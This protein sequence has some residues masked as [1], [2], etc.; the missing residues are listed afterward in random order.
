[1]T[2]LQSSPELP[3]SCFFVRT[4]FPELQRDRAFGSLIRLVV[5]NQGAEGTEEGRQKTEEPSI[6]PKKCLSKHDARGTWEKRGPSF[7]SA[8]CSSDIEAPSLSS[9][10][11]ATLP[12][13]SSP[14]T[15]SSHP[16]PVAQHLASLSGGPG[17]VGGVSSKHGLLSA[18]PPHSQNSVAPVSSLLAPVDLS[19]INLTSV[20]HWLGTM[21]APQ[22]PSSSI[23]PSSLADPT[24]RK[25]NCLPSSSYSC[26]PGRSEPPLNVADALPLPPSAS[27]S[28]SS[29]P[30]ERICTA[31]AV[32]SS[33]PS[34][35]SPRPPV[36][37][38]VSSAVLGES[39]GGSKIYRRVSVWQAGARALLQRL[40]SIPGHALVNV[41]SAFE[42]ALIRDPRLMRSA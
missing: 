15:T 38:A 36:L 10:S 18:S 32:A 16:E 34:L 31:V 28:C 19:P 2:S 13:S 23:C 42:K 30:P 1:M 4:A 27:S 35:S 41:Y 6:G 17:S 3:S 24:R 25:W 22:P 29:P 37:D 14:V 5:E 40:P 39:G 8:S 20:I 11:S 33:S 26:F 9:S 21:A 12:I 7:S